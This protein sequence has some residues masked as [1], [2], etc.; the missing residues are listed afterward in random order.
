MGG[1]AVMKG[2]D[3]GKNSTPAQ[4]GMQLWN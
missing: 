4:G 2:F 1:A 3:E